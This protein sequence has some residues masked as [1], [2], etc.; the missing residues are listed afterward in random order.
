MKQMF[1]WLK[2]L[3]GQS[4]TPPPIQAQANES[5]EERGGPA[6]SWDDLPSAL[7][8]V[9]LGARSEA[10][11]A[12]ARPAV[13]LDVI[14]LDESE[15]PL[16]AS[17][18][19]G[20]PDIPSSTEWPNFEGEGLS[21]VAQ[22]DLAQVAPLAPG[23]LPS[24]GLLSFFYDNE[25]W[26]SDPEDCAGWSVLWTP[27]GE[28]LVRREEPADM[29]EYGEVF[30]SCLLKPRLVQTLPSIESDIYNGLGLSE[31]ENEAYDELLLELGHPSPVQVFGYPDPVQREMES[32]CEEAS[33]G[34]YEGD[35]KFGS[36]GNSNWRL[37]LQVDSVDEAGMMWGDV[38]M[39]YFWIREEDL[40][41]Q[42][43]DRVWMIMQCS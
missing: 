27:A 38:G 39:L 6:P 40:V 30:D 13:G 41:A 21:F 29:G 7:E 12:L 25:V 36:S 43:F 5:A 4:S 10:I 37:L 14:E 26:G 18:L 8:Q 23:P 3:L 16:G 32:Q 20:F 15:I 34:L 35:G 9:G 42:R 17:K 22:L 2:R 33:T 11:L 24:S 31:E 19:G 1:S 28:Q